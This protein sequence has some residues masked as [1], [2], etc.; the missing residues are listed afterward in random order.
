MAQITL[1]TSSY[2]FAG[3]IRVNW[4]VLRGS[5]AR[6]TT[7]FADLVRVYCL[8]LAVVLAMF[9]SEHSV[10][11][12]TNPN[13]VIILADDL[14]W[15]DTTLHGTTKLYQ[16]PNIKRLAKRGISFTRAYSAS[17]LCS[18]TR[19]ALLTGLSPARTGITS[20]NC[21]VPQVV[22]EATLGKNGPPTKHAI[23]PQPVTRLKTDYPTLA[24]TFKKAGYATGHFGKWHLG[25][26]PYSALQ[27]G[28][29]VDVP[30]HA[31]PG[32]AGSYVAP[33]K[34]KDFDHDPAV[35]DEHIEDRMA[36]EAVS[37]ME[38]H[39][40]KPFF[41]NY[42]MFSVHAPFDAKQALIEKYRGLVNPHDPQRCPT[43]AA[44]VESMDDAVG[45]LLDTLDRLKI[46]DNTIIVF[47]SDNGGNMYNE[48]EGVPPTSNL[49]L[50]GGKA[51]MFEG[52]TRVPC[53]VVWPDVATAGAKSDALVQSEDFFPTL[54]E[55]LKL[56][57]DTNQIFD[58][59]SIIPAFKGDPLAGK[60]VFQFFP[61]DPPVPDWIP[62]SV[63]VH[64]D[65]WK[66][67]RIFHAGEQ[68]A[69][70][71][72][73]FNLHADL[74][75]HNNLATTMP[76]K[77]KEL[78]SMIDRYLAET[79]AVVPISNPAFDLTKYKPELE[80]LRPASKQGNPKPK[81]TSKPK[82]KPKPAGK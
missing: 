68:G 49:P 18:P 17:P 61:H 56:E 69:H 5:L 65:E 15:S 12:Q 1:Q 71:Y 42:W 79:N 76:D 23:A 81:A 24:K 30:H 19:S 58:G 77:V 16:T 43:Y 60:A 41:L 8:T 70:R 55:G 57:A 48:V 22:L 7:Q 59:K 35:P 74:G 28:F 32:P 14:G 46:A 31:G 39:Q 44:M 29:D 38:Q 33:W 2:L 47:T 53:I 9:A 64:Q 34:F 62:P 50:R 51:S 20:P 3:R 75:E 45:T 11:A 6:S 52:G 66:L 13:V 78:D 80:G 36:T 82:A 37:F 25:P 4:S 26:E 73:L 72:L 63:S 67:I 54:L 27:H 21:H 40:D 10:Q